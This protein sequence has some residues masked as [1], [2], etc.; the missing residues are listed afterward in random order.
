MYNPKSFQFKMLRPNTSAVKHRPVFFFLSTRP[1]LS[2]EKSPPPG[3][4][5]FDWDFP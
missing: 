3:L 2:E 1:F 5:A 4:Q